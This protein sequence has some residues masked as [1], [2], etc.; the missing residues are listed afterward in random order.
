MRAG[1]A[2]QVRLRPPRVVET[3]GRRQIGDALKLLD[4]VTMIGRAAPVVTDRCPKTARSPSW[5][6]RADFKGE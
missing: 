3:G 1:F 4:M 6:Y 5:C 2:L